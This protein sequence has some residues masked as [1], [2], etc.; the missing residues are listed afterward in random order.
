MTDLYISRN[1]RKN[2]LNP[3]LAKERKNK[4]KTKNG[5]QINEISI[6]KST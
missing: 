1:Y 4:I 5:A 2:N 6:S 3:V